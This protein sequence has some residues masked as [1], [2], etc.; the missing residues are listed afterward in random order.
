MNKI[1]LKNIIIGFLLASSFFIWNESNSQVG[2]YEYIGDTNILNGFEILDTETGRI[3]VHSAGNGW[4]RYTEVINDT[5]IVD[6]EGNKVTDRSK[7]LFDYI[8]T[9]K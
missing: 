8:K 5:N 7:T 6:L 2:R 3:Y 1:D 4:L 9:E